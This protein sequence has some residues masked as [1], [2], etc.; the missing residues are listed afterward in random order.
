MGDTE[1][2]SESGEPAVP[3]SLWSKPRRGCPGSTTPVQGSQV[4]EQGLAR[5][6][7]ENG[8]SQR[9]PEAG[10][11]PECSPAPQSV[12]TA[13]PVRGVRAQADIAGNQQ[14]WEGGADLPDGLDGRSALG[15]GSRASLVL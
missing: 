3:P 7:A 10:K 13:V 9:L 8:K 1:G 4:L 11:G 6:S 2:C 14:L 15:I 5:P 12:L